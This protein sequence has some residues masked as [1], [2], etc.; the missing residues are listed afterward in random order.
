[1]RSPVTW[2]PSRPTIVTPVRIVI[3]AAAVVAAAIAISG[4]WPHNIP[5]AVVRNA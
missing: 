4:Q 1:M 3:G 2:S 5:R